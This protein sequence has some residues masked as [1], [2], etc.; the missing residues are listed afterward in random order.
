MRKAPAKARAVWAGLTPVKRAKAIMRIR[1]WVEAW[2]AEWVARGRKKDTSPPFAAT[3]LEQERWDD[4]SVQAAASPPAEPEY[5][6][7]DPM[8]SSAPHEPDETEVTRAQA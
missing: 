2:V 3:W 8:D 5:P 7:E 1:P 4:G 6:P